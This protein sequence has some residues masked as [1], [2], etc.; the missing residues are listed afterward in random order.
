MSDYTYRLPL[1]KK[2]LWRVRR[3]ERN[4]RLVTIKA[5]AKHAGFYRCLVETYDGEGHIDGLAKFAYAADAWESPFGP[6]RLEN[7]EVRRHW[8]GGVKV[9]GT[10]PE[11]PGY[12][13]KVNVAVDFRLPD[14]TLGELKAD[15][16]GDGDGDALRTLT[17]TLTWELQET[18]YGPAAAEAV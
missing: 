15:V 12:G 1:E 8:N 14:V 11:Y 10:V 2:Y 7:L 4:G 3:A 13:R 18:D 6:G 9:R 17:R 5:R 16:D